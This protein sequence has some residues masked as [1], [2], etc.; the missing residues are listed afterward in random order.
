MIILALALPALSLTC[1]NPKFRGELA[2]LWITLHWMLIW[3]SHCKKYKKHLNSFIQG[4]NKSAKT[5]EQK[6]LQEHCWMAAA[7]FVWEAVIIHIS[8]RKFAF[9]WGC[10]IA[11]KAG[12]HDL[13]VSCLGLGTQIYIAL[14]SPRAWSSEPSAIQVPTLY[15]LPCCLIPR[16]T[17]ATLRSNLKLWGSNVHPYPPAARRCQIQPFTGACT[18]KMNR[19][20]F[21]CTP[22]E[23]LK[24]ET[25]FR[26]GI[27]WRVNTVTL[28]NTFHE[29]GAREMY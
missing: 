17:H 23:N 27:K 10:T 14:L 6:H 12:C 9:G 24:G 4:K 7:D 26:A 22:W 19:C 13:P 15:P 20:L 5:H 11:W 21:Q 2:T 25:Y 8:L 3:A 18:S 29:R 16:S 1:Q 28:K